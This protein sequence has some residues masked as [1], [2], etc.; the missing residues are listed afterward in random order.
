MKKGIAM[1]LITALV[2]E[3][4]GC[5]SY[6]QLSTGQDYEM[7]ENLNDIE[8]LDLESRL[9]G[10]I[11]FHEKFPGKIENE[12]VYGFQ[13]M[14]LPYSASNSIVFNTQDA[15]PVY[16]INNGIQYKI[17]S[18]NRSGFICV[19]EDTIRTP[20]SDIIQMTVREKDPLKTTLLIMGLSSVF[21][22]MMAYLIGSKFTIYTQGM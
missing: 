2:I 10:I 19:S 15:N 16:I 1:V 13:Q 20:F 6:R 3:M 5:S 14:H 22:G 4:T 21:I 18:Q 8:V 11:V 9:D 17:I 12:Q 7:F